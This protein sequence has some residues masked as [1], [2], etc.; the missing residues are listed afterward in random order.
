VHQQGLGIEEQSAARDLVARR[1]HAQPS[2][3]A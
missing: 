2:M 3:N 1:S